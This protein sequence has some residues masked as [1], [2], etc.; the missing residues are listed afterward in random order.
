MKKILVIIFFLLFAV[1]HISITANAHPVD[2]ID[3]DRIFSEHGSIML[4]IDMETVAIEHANN[5]AAEFYGYPI[6]QLERMAIFDIKLFSPGET[7][8][9]ISTFLEDHCNNL[10]L[11]QK[12]ANDEIRTVEVYACPYE[13]GD[14]TL[15]F[16]TV[17][18][19]TEKE[20]QISKIAR[21][22]S[23]AEY[24]NSMINNRDNEVLDKEQVISE[25][26]TRRD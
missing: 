21:M 14:R 23:V 6:E 7:T 18:D 1:L 25:L 3:F 8:D 16:A 4:L 9:N 10:V 20:D 11:E 12:L 13:Y 2:G 19:I 24:N 17:Y 15:I 22:I 5:S 26:K